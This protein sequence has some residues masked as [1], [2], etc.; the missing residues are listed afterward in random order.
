M[1]AIMNRN[2][3]RPF[4]KA[5]N[6]RALRA[7]RSLVTTSAQGARTAPTNTLLGPVALYATFTYR[8]PPSNRSEHAIT[9]NTTGDLDKLVR[10]IGDSLTDAKW[11]DD[12]VQV[13]ELHAYKRWGQEDGVE[14]SVHDLSGKE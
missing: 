11:W 13:V 12:D 5:S 3:G 2:T 9:K 8:K 10:A 14:V 7:W 4:L 1:S 6:E